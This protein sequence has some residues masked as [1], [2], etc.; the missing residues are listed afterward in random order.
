[1]NWRHVAALAFLAL[2]FIGWRMPAEDVGRVVVLAFT[3][4]CAV[5]ILV[6]VGVVVSHVIPQRRAVGRSNGRL[7]EKRGNIQG[8]RIARL[9]DALKGLRCTRL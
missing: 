7:R 2:A 5:P 8:M 3:V 9:R 6:L 1:M 4:A